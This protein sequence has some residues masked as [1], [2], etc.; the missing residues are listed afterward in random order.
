MRHRLTT[1]TLALALLGGAFSAPAHAELATWTNLDG[2]AMQAEF[3]GRKGDYVSF[4]KDD[5]SRYLYPYAKLTEADR[6]RV[7]GLASQVVSASGAVSQIP[8][9]P[10]N[11]ARP[12][13][14]ASA[15]SGKL[16]S[17]R[18]E[19][20]APVPR[21]QILGA[22]HIAL[23]YSAHW[24]PPCRAFTPELVK[25]YA[26]I[27]AKHPDFELVFVSSDRDADEMKGYMKE[28]GM[29][30][31]AV[32]YDQRG[33]G[34]LRRPDHERG[35]PNL[36]FLDAEGKALSVSYTPAGDYLGPQKVLADIKKHYRL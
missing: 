3:L 28:Y 11:A 16:V 20:L 30:F 13:E 10:A 4:R 29:G 23:Y 31:T 14:L 32:R 8:A 33:L 35:I 6:Q 2:V 22:K 21:E 1:A 9:A 25:A 18:G 15:L 19:F 27:K 26:A 7:D 5:G 24:C 17:L 12:G 34:A 36:V